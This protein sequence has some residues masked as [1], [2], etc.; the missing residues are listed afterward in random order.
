MTLNIDRDDLLAAIMHSYS[1]IKSKSEKLDYLSRFLHLNAT[2]ADQRLISSF[3]TTASELVT[4][5][6]ADF[7]QAAITLYEMLE[8][9]DIDGAAKVIF[10]DYMTLNMDLFAVMQGMGQFDM[11]RSVTQPL[12]KFAGYTV[13][14]SDYVDVT[15]NHVNMDDQSATQTV[16]TSSPFSVLM[17][18]AQGKGIGDVKKNLAKSQSP[19]KLDM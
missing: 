15:G 17:N 14:I 1:E 7:K 2:M 13:A 9:D 3:N 12:V 11:D 6:A 4:P 10:T 8:T 16:F 19:F 18:I 5:H